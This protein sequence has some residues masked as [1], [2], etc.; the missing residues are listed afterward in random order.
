M[1]KVTLSVEYGIVNTALTAGALLLFGGWEQCHVLAGGVGSDCPRWEQE[2]H[3]EEHKCPAD[4]LDM[5][6]HLL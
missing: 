5:Q 2:A 3:R 1:N 4:G 6:F